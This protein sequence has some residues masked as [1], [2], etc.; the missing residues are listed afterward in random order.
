[1]NRVFVF[2]VCLLSGSFSFAQI[3]E[4]GIFAGGSN[5]IGDVGS[6]TYISPEKLAVGVMYKWNRSPRHSWR[7]S[8]TQS[9]LSAND[10]DSDS[11]ARQQ[12][13]YAFKNDLKEV[14]LGLEFN[15]FDFNLHDGKQKFTPYVYT[16]LSGFIYQEMYFA[17]GETKDDY[18]AGGLAVPMILGF[19]TNVSDN[20]I[21]GIEAGA[22]WTFTDNLDGS[23]PKN[24]NLEALKFGN[25]N[26]NDWYVFTGLTLT[27]TFGNKP[28]YCAD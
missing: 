13:G 18:R 7:I 4:I 25:I 22:R 12:R 15:F 11:Q 1:M 28:C 27:Y 8:F 9:Q 21:I 17:A 16:G 24:E 2:F 26:N 6:T 14:S 5:Y 3:H 19:K 20:W 23:N 10:A